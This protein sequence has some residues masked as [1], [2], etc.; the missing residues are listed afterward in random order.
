M[1]RRVRPAGS[2]VGAADMIR[3]R[4]TRAAACLA[5][6][7]SPKV[8]VA[9]YA[10]VAASLRRD[11]GAATGDD[12]GHGQRVQRLHQQG[13]QAGRRRGQLGA[14]PPGDAGGKGRRRFPGTPTHM[15]PL[16]AERP[17]DRFVVSV[18]LTSS[19]AGVAAPDS[20]IA[21]VRSSPAR[22]LSI[23]PSRLIY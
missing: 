9:R 7:R 20:V 23:T 18:K 19:F 15:Q 22:F 11:P 10:M 21:T 1:A 2:G 13:P 17:P 8:I 16:D 6:A 4:R 12:A 3:M 5:A 14:H